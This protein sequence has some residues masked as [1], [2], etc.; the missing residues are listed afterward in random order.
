MS[1]LLSNLSIRN[2]IFLLIAAIIVIVA[3]FAVVAS[4]YQNKLIKEIEVT[5]HEEGLEA[6]QLI[7]NADRDMYQA[8]VAVQTLLST[9]D[10]KQN[11]DKYL[12]EFNENVSQTSERINNARDILVKSN[13]DWKTYIDSESGKT[14]FEHFSS[15][16]KEFPEWISMSKSIMEARKLLPDWETKFQASRASVDQIDNILNDIINSKIEQQFALYKAATNTMI[17]IASIVLLAILLLAYIIT[18]NITVPLK[19]VVT[20]IQEMGKGHLNQ[21]LKIDRKDEIGVLAHTMDSFADD[22][23]NVV[24][25]SMHKI[26][27]GDFSINITEKDNDD[28]ITPALK[29]TISS[30]KGL[31][32]EA[33]ML[34]QAAANGDLKVRGDADKFKGGYRDILMGINS[35]LDAVIEPLNEAKLVLGKM[36]LNDYTAQMQGQYKGMLKEFSDAINMLRTRMLSVQDAFIKVSKGDTSQL[37]EFTAS[38]KMCDDDKLVPAIIQMLQTIQNLINEVNVLSCSAIEGR[39]SVRG[40]TDNFE[41]AYKQIIN[42]LNR[43]MDAVSEPI[44]ES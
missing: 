27:D 13:S 41:G 6:I 40:N 31:I 35:T 42:G 7:L 23:Q 5:V 37:D 10:S 20:M 34:T 3:T 17:L 11:T 43:T 1:K 15:F 33:N 32:S 18:K 38:G 25:G 8:Y 29:K 19:K 36:S 2:K 22:L 26:A 16:D 4:S 30:I 14:V 28:E 21:R 39:L 12:N 44:S 9:E 24:V